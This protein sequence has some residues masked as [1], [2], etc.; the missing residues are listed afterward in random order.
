V[1]SIGDMTVVVMSSLGERAEALGAA[2]LVL[3]TTRTGNA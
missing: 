1:P 2:A 3:Q